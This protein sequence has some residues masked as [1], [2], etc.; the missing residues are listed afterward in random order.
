LAYGLGE[1]I[2]QTYQWTST[3]Q[4]LPTRFSW[5]VVSEKTRFPPHCPERHKPACGVAGVRKRVLLYIQT[6]GEKGSSKAFQ[7]GPS[8]G[9]LP[10]KIPGAMSGLPCPCSAPYSNMSE[11]KK[12][13]SGFRRGRGGD[14]FSFTALNETSRS[15]FL[16]GLQTMENGLV[17]QSYAATRLLYIQP[18]GEKGSNQRRKVPSQIGKKVGRGA[19]F[20]KLRR[21]LFIRSISRPGQ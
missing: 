5:G 19:E 18:L 20:K 3:G 14:P 15:F 8:L 12:A 10:G 11:R 4:K 1:F 21:S 9:E 7:R 2:D 13:P 16:S 6:W 17:E